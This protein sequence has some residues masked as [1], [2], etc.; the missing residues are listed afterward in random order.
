MVHAITCTEASA[1]WVEMVTFLAPPFKRFHDGEDWENPDTLSTS[2]TLFDVI[3]MSFLED[4]HGLPI[5][6][7]LSLDC[8]V[9]LAMG[10]VILEHVDHLDHAVEVKDGVI[11]TLPE[12]KAALVTRCPIWP[13]TFTLT[14]TTVS[15]DQGW[16]CTRRCGCFWDRKEQSLFPTPVFCS[17]LTFQ[18]GD[19][20]SQLPTSEVSIFPIV[21]ENPCLSLHLGVLPFRGIPHPRWSSGCS[22][23]L[24][25][26]AAVLPT[27]R[28][29]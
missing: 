24:E 25:H 26:W 22:G 4:R 8:A 10:R 16:H 14:F 11:L 3:R 19:S 29:T 5:D 7:I 20:F 6:D 13:N 17:H 21:M 28:L 9:E 27:A 1:E 23:G 12:K 18:E 15:K 2:M